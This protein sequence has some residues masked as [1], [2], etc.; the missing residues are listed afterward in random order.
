MP[1]YIVDTISTF[2]LR[3]AIEAKCLEHAYDEVVMNE[4]NH[5]FDDLTQKHLGEQIIDG[6]QVTLEEYT[7]LLSDLKE[8]PGEMSSYWMGEKLIHKIAYNDQTTESAAPT[9]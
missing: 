7:Q 3:Y 4:S 1:I 2:R 8:T 5:T 9:V 6:K